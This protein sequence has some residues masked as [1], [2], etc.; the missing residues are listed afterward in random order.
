MHPAARARWRRPTAARRRAG[1]HGAVDP[2][3]TTESGNYH[4][5]YVHDGSYGDDA[6]HL[7]VTV[8]GQF[9]FNIDGHE[10]GEHATVSY[11]TWVQI[12]G[13]QVWSDSQTTEWSGQIGNVLSP[14]FYGLTAGPIGGYGWT[15]F[16]YDLI[17]PW[18]QTTWD[19]TAQFQ[20]TGT[21]RMDGHTL[22]FSYFTS[23]WTNWKTTHSGTFAA[24]T[25]TI[26]SGPSMTGG[27]GSEHLV[28]DAKGAYRSDLTVS[29]S[30]ANL[31]GAGHWGNNTQESQLDLPATV[32][33]SVYDESQSFDHFTRD[34]GAG[35]WDAQVP[36][37]MRSSARV[38]RTKSMRSGRVMRRTRGCTA[39]RD[40]AR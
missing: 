32:N 26:D 21:F 29:L 6:F 11:S 2:A 24:G 37:A 3:T 30:A 15:N 19:D 12:D 27:S 31:P 20:S 22:N 9:W 14:T 1:Q 10:N 25:A 5:H 16:G 28:T 39:G 8:V 18:G 35:R 33:P 23:D 38:C 40:K 17:G 36:S 4:R 34:L 7:D 13:E